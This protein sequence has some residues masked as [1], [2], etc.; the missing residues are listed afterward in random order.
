MD[1]RA[2]WRLQLERQVTHWDVASLALTDPTD[3]APSA[4]WLALER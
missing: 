4:S 1:A 2:A 3:F